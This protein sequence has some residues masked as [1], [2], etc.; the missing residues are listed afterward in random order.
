LA[1]NACKIAINTTY[2]IPIAQINKDCALDITAIDIN[3]NSIFTVNLLNE[4]MTH[5]KPTDYIDEYMLVTESMTYPQKFEKAKELMDRAQSQLVKISSG[6]K[7]YSI[8]TRSFLFNKQFKHFSEQ[9]CAGAI[10]YVE[11]KTDKMEQLHL[12]ALI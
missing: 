11:T 2:E 7:T 4:L 12:T 3:G 6:Q 9:L 8:D 5:I 10:I 1:Y